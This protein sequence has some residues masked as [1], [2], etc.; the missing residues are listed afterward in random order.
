M[1]RGIDL[2]C[3]TRPLTRRKAVADV[4]MV[5]GGLALGIGAR[6]ETEQEISRTAESIHQETFFK[7]SRRRVFEA[8]TDT[9]Q[10]DKV[11]ILSGARNSQLGNRPTEISRD[12]GGAFVLFGGH[13][14]GRQIEL[15]P[16]ERIVQAWRVIDWEPGVYSIAKFVLIE[17][18]SGTRIVFDHTGFPKGLAEHLAA[19][20]IGHYWEP[21]TKFLTQA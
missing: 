9:K 18:G 8:L 15:V 16:N 10:F 5:L 20:W 13:I 6:A 21:L 14:I 4:A 1:G 7:A 19:G 2:G 12:L 11:I 3:L 17:Q